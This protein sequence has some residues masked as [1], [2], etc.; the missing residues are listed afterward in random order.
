MNESHYTLPY[1]VVV[2]FIGSSALLN[3]GNKRKVSVETSVSGNK[4]VVPPTLSVNTLL[5]DDINSLPVGWF[6]TRHML[7]V[8]L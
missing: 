5:N 2:L 8:I 6:I 1:P 4:K 3:L 7:L